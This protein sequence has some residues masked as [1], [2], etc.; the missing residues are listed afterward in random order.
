MKKILITS[1][2]LSAAL[3]LVAADSFTITGTIP[4]LK[5]GTKVQLVGRDRHSHGDIAGTTATDGAFTLTGSV[6]SPTLC[7]IRIESADPEGLDKAIGLMVENLPMTVSAAHIDSVAPGFYTGTRGKYLERNVAVTGGQAQR[8]FDEYNAAMFPYELVSKQA[9]YDLYW[10]EDQKTRSEDEEKRLAAV[11]NDANAAET[12]ARRAFIAAHPTYSIS[13]YLVL[14]DLNTPFTYTASELDAMAASFKDMPDAARLSQITEA[15]DFNR[16]YQRET[17]YTDIAMLDTLGIERKLSEFATGDRYVMID[18]WAS[19]CG[20]CRA[21]IP[22]VREL[23]GKYGDRLEILAVSLDSAEKP[24]RKAMEQEKMEW[25]Q[26]WADKTRSGAITDAYQVHS[27]PFMLL[28][29]PQ[30]RIV[31]AGHDPEALSAFLEKTL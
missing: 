12:S 29:D 15:L 17:P 7:E 9:H 6:T 10:G 14:N 3:S 24:W 8:E 2:L 13:G 25:T 19:W 11:F 1:A 5:A 20:P 16:K 28:L 4:G 31:H 26:L 18:F 22:H 27:I 30:G 21:A 23:R